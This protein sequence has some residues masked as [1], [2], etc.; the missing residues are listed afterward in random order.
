MPNILQT[1]LTMKQSC[2]KQM[3]TNLPQTRQI[4][5]TIVFF[6][7]QQIK[8]F[9][10]SS[11]QF[12]RKSIQQEKKNS[13]IIARND[14]IPFYDEIKFLTDKNNNKSSFNNTVKTRQRNNQVFFQ[15]QM[16]P[17]KSL[18]YTQ[19]KYYSRVTSRIKIVIT[20]FC[21]QIQNKFKFDSN[22]SCN[23]YSLLDFNFQNKTLFLIYNN[24]V[25]KLNY[26]NIKYGFQMNVGC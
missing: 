26:E 15:T 8:S 23:Q 9:H 6:K 2:H 12:R 25:C 17:T 19:Q 14:F 11:K 22:Q 1:Q 10:Q 5:H 21:N 16:I 20:E 4:L 13:R 24:F 18:K 7:N 3:A